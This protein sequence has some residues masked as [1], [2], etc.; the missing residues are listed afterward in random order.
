M[1]A[2]SG[3]LVE[4]IRWADYGECFEGLD[5]ITQGRGKPQIGSMVREDA[6]DVGALP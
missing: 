5:R 2:G 4:R 3:L 6:I 1:E